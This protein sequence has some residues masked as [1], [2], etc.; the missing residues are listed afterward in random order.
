MIYP[1]PRHLRAFVTIAATGSLAAAARTLHIG[2]PALSQA[3][4]NLEELVGVR[5]LERTTR[6]LVLT[7]AG[8]EFLRDAQRVLQENERLVLHGQQWAQARRGRISLLTVPSVAH[9]LLPGIV[10]HFSASRPEVVIEVHDHA[11]PVLRQHIQRGEG[12]VAIF[13]KTQAEADER[14]LPFLRDP[15]RFV[16]HCDHPL[17]TAA[18]VEGRQLGD[19]RLILMRQ[20]TLFRAYADTVLRELRLKYA[21]VEVD[22]PA[23]LI[24]MVEA[25]LGVSL[26]PGLSCPPAAL[27][28]VVSVPLVK[29]DVFRQI[30]FFRAGEREPMPAVSAFVND[31]LDF[32]M[33][34]PLSLPVGV[35][36]SRPPAAD[37]AR[38][39]G[40]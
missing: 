36:L 2:Q 17:A 20:G 9:R 25:G 15:F 16:C 28:T 27:H 8:H 6:S 3:L 35:Q 18:Q 34:A 39:L 12:D 14:T 40:N 30:V 19:E 4:V 32:L 33:Q 23:T 1:N 22:Q 13:T 21:P 10:R 24:G 26:L 7:A 5:L 29:P 38:F 31:A 11:D 37:I